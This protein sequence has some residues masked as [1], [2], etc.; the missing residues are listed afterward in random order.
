MTLGIGLLILVMRETHRE[1]N[2]IP[3]HTA[4]KKYESFPHPSDIGLTIYGDTLEELFENAAL[5][6]F[7]AL[8]NIEQVKEVNIVDVRVKGDDREGLLVN[9]LNEL[10]YLQG[11]KGWLFRKVAVEKLN[12]NSIAAKG[13]GEP[14]RLE[15]H[16]LFHEIKCATYHNLHI[17]REDDRWRVDVVFDV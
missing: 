4:K 8:C 16:E 3:M 6:M 2:G 14:Y 1:L 5:G 10:L 13:W 17:R 12:D 7:D 11:V 9:F 15:T